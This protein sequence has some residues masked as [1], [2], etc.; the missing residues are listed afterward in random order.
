MERAGIER[1]NQKKVLCFGDEGTCFLIKYS[2][3]SLGKEENYFSGRVGKYLI[4]TI[5]SRF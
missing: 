1:G 4:D 2:R 5:R 3:K